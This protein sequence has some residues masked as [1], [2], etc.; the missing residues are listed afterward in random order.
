M[1]DTCTISWKEP[2][3]VLQ[4]DPSG[5]VMATAKYGKGAV[6]ALV[7]AWLYNQYANSKSLPPGNENLGAGK[8]LV[9]WLVRSVP[10]KS[11]KSL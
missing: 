6:F 11:W 4:Q 5:M 10:E 3:V 9:R 8:E 7:D 2:A 1:K